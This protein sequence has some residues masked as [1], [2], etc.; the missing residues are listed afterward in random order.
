MGTRYCRTRWVQDDATQ[1]SRVC[2]HVCA[3]ISA[4]YTSS[5]SS[6]DASTRSYANGGSAFLKSGRYQIRR[7][8]IA[9]EDLHLVLLGQK[10]LPL[11]QIEGNIHPGEIKLRAAFFRKGSPRMQEHKRNFVSASG[12]EARPQQRYA[13]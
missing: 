11:Q 12:P 1:L 10:D 7:H 3:S 6:A 9:A 8:H 5:R 13:V 2:R 4:E